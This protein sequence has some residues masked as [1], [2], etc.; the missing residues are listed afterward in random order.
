MSLFVICKRQESITSTQAAS[1]LLS[2]FCDDEN[3][4]AV[5]FL[6]HHRLGQINEA[7]VSWVCVKRSALYV[8]EYLYMR[9]NVWLYK[10]R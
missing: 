9:A 4:W 6:T 8:C 1:E 3:M 10:H 7:F 2:L 5:L